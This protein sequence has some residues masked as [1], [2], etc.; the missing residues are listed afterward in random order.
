MSRDWL[1]EHFAERNVPKQGFTTFSEAQEEA[2][3]RN[4]RDVDNKH[5][6]RAYKCG[7]CDEFHLGHSQPKKW[8]RGRR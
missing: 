7:Y 4:A 2:E 6:W 1:A 3:R 5:P 8:K